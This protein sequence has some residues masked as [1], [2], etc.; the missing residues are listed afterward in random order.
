MTLRTRLRIAIVALVVV[1]VT[2]LS[3]LYLFDFTR[4][5]FDNAGDMGRNIADNVKGY[6]V[7]R[8]GRL[9]S[10]RSP[11]P[12]SLDEYI[13]AWTEIV[14]TDPSIAAMLQRS[15]ANAYM[16]ANVA[17]AG[18][19]GRILA[20]S[21]PTTRGLPAPA[22]GDVENAGMESIDSPHP[23]A[24]LIE[25]FRMRR[26]YAVVL[27]LGVPGQTKPIF[28]IVVVIESIFLRHAL[29]PA[30][31][32]LA[33][34]FASALAV[35][36]LLGFLLPNLALRP[37][38][39]VSRR[40]DEIR[41][42][43]FTAAAASE[44]REFADVQ[45]KLNLLGQQYRG[46]REDALA[47]RGSIEGMLERLQETVLLFDASGRLSVAGHMVERLLG[48]PRGELLGRAIGELFPAS[49]PI[50][51]AIA[52]ARDSQRAI[53]DEIVTLDGV[54]GRPGARLLVNTEPLGEPGAPS[55]GVL[56]RLS[57]A[58]TRTQIQQHLDLASRLTAISRL[59]GGV[60][61]EIKNP[62]NAITLHLEVLKTRLEGEDPEIGVILNE[63]RRLDRVVKT[64]LDFTRPVELQVRDFDLARLAAET[65]AFLAPQA[66]AKPAFLETDL[67]SPLWIR[68]D[69][70]LLRQALVNVLVNALDA[71]APGGRVRVA[72]ER[73]GGECVLTV[74][75]DGPGIPPEIRSKIFN[76][77]FTT[78]K[79]GS[80]IGLAMTFRLVQLH[81]G[82]I[83]VAGDSG[84]GA[85]F[86]IRLPEASLAGEPEAPV[87]ARG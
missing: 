75:D 27:P 54:D 40:I 60:A 63:V 68:G 5:A 31:R 49:T 55:S 4:A 36:M 24:N 65:V 83:D 41:A 78:K 12:A 80:G 35:S 59:T 39:R 45:S 53:R 21:D 82:T 14:R 43:K 16:V 64:F 30:F 81:G 79:S 20:A 66:A 48:R 9:L 87:A 38:E 22:L 8:F 67:V 18:Q 52:A 72:A 47:L 57:D 44:A 61:H 56:V 19:D 15:R 58:E 73:V 17:I 46:A 11:P 74:A 1:V 10:E 6:T 77:Y 7:E 33:A 51:A 50:G 76:L 28:T 69:A 42:G 85:T 23:L 70:E 29:E 62:L 84:Q 25:L 86:R 13:G 37:L 2:G 26:N 71:I 32:N 34:A 3:A